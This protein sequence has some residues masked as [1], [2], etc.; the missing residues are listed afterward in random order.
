MRLFSANSTASVEAK[1][2]ATRSQQIAH[3]SRL[4]QRSGRDDQCCR[5]TFGQKLNQEL[6]QLSASLS[7]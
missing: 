1:A 6:L 2:I 4:S 7:K 5:A 3:A